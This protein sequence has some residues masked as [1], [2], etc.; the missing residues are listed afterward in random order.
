MARFLYISSHLFAILLYVSTCNREPIPLLKRSVQKEVI[1]MSFSCNLRWTIC[2]IS[3]EKQ[4]LGWVRIIGVIF[5][6]QI[7]ARQVHDYVMILHMRKS[8]KSMLCNKQCSTDGIFSTIFPCKGPINFGRHF[9]L[10]LKKVWC[11]F[12]LSVVHMNTPDYS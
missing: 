5:I 10:Y 1:E 9:D 4:V 12:I 7:H 8:F 3:K 11:L 2:H 6:V